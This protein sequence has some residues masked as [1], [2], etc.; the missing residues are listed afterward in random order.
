M[1]VVQS[2]TQPYPLP[3]PGALGAC[4]GDTHTSALGASRDANTGPMVPSRHVRVALTPGCQIG[5]METI[6]AAI[7]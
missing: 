7:N 3:P 2:A 5:Y 1:G 4:A 6:L